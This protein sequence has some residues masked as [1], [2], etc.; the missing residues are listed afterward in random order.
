MEEL[1]QF[2][3]FTYRFIKIYNINKEGAEEIKKQFLLICALTLSLTLFA[4]E[5][6]HETIV[7][8]IEV[9]VRVFK[10]ST[11]IDN[12]TIDDFE[13]YEDAKLQ[14]IEAVYLIKKTKIE[15]EEEVTK[16]KFTPEVSRNFIFV[17]EIRDNFPEIGE[18]LDYFFNNVLLPGDTL[19]IV[20]PIKTYSIKNNA[21]D[22]LPKQEIAN[23]LKGKLKNDIIMGSADYRSLCKD[24]ERILNTEGLDGDLK[25]LM[26]MD[27]LRMLKELRYF[28]QS[29]L[30]KLSDNLKQIKGQKHVFLFYQKKIMPIPTFLEPHDKLDLQKNIFFDVETIKRAFSD[31]SISSHFLFLTKTPMYV[32]DITRRTSFENSGI[33]MEDHSYEI[34]SAFSEMARATGGLIESSANPGFLFKRAAEASENYYLLFYAPLNYQRDGK[35]KNIKVIVKGKRYKVTHRAGY[36]A[37]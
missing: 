9:P 31:S 15:R 16:K 4:Q 28:D 3:P 23:Q 10:G 30:L 11:F 18:V 21:L 34:F 37:N 19:E 7:V 36:F 26:C 6:A 25:K 8:N 13:V 29:K 17:F 20:T 32:L 35:F 22:I 12:L 5:L 1:S 33:Q 2:A 24:L 27:I 14:K